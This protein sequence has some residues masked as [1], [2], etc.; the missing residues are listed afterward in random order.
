MNIISKTNS[1][2]KVRWQDVVARYAH[3]DLQRSLWQAINS[4][5]PFF[6]L[7]VLMAFS[8]RISYLVT[9]LLAIP[10][11]GF[12]VRT[13]IIFHD[14]G[15]GS[16]FKSKKANDML[17]IFTGLISFTPYYR[18]RHEHAVHHAT[19]GDLDRR[20]VGDVYTMTVKEY[21]D[22]P[23]WKKLGYR[24]MRNPFNMFVL[25]PFFCLCSGQPDPHPQPGK[26]RT[27]QRVVDEPGPD[28]DRRCIVLAHRVADVP[29]GG[30]AGFD[31]GHGCWSLA[32]LCPA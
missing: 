19:A 27:R 16:F 22:A 30:S 13:F 6:A 26:T 32:V 31:D 7:W 20:G 8:V 4:L 24:L 14:C 15:H 1:N 18:W 23:W 17:G 28:G 11:A 12:M 9:L 3:P 5:V 29:D 2:E 10:T 25:A 21:L